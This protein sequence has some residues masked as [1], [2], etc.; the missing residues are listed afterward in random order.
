[1][2]EVETFINYSELRNITFSVPTP[3]YHKVYANVKK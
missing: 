1:M 2:T 3:L